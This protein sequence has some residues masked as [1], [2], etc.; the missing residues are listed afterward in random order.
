M[1][2]T[3]R[4]CDGVFTEYSHA[5][6]IA[7]QYRAVAVALR[8]EQRRRAHGHDDSHACCAA[9]LSNPAYADLN[10]A[11]SAPL[12]FELELLRVECMHRGGAAAADACMQRCTS[13]SCGRCRRPTSAPVWRR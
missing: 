11:V 1:A 13:G 6:Q 7:L 3:I 8:Q 5:V 10:A 4:M 12:A 9:A 2:S